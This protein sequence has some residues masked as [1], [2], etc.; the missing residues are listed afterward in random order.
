MRER[1]PSDSALERACLDYERKE[2]TRELEQIL[3]KLRGD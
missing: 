2:L 1:E 3:K